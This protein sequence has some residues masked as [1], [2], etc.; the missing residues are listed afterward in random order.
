[1]VYKIILINN[2][3][4]LAVEETEISHKFLNSQVI[5]NLKKYNCKDYANMVIYKFADKFS[6]LVI[7]DDDIPANKVKPHE[8]KKIQGVSIA[9]HD[10]YV[11]CCYTNKNINT[12]DD[13]ISQLLRGSS[14][15]KITEHN[16]YSFDFMKVVFAERGFV[17]LSSMEEMFE[18]CVLMFI[19]SLAYNYYNSA[20]LSQMSELDQRRDLKEMINVRDKYFYYNLL[21]YFTNPIKYQ[22][23]A[24]F[25]IWEKMSNFYHVDKVHNEVKSQLNDLVGI[26]QNK[27]ETRFQRFISVLGVIVAI[28]SVFA[29][30]K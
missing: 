3:F 9:D 19:V 6:F 1:M 18:R 29:A 12:D 4:S 20:L 5:K 10:S 7:A 30:F 16:S 2:D 27:I 8:I 26:I 15:L 25:A 28:I 11:Y 14:S 21:V 13:S 23:Y 24:L 22:R 17:L